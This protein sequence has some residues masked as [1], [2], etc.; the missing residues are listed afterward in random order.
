MFSEK[1]SQRGD[2]QENAEQ[3]ENKMKP[4]HQRDAAQDHDSAHDQR[5]EDSPH[6]R[7]MLSPRRH[8]EISK[9]Q[10]ENKDV[11]DAQRIF[12]EVSTKKIE[13]MLWSFE[14]P[15]QRV[16]AKRYQHPQNAPLSGSVHA[17]FVIAPFE[18]DQ[19]NGDRDKDADV[20]GD[21]K[22][23]AG[24]HGVLTFHGR[25]FTPIANTL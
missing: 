19:I 5:A 7:A 11:I 6:Q 21:P 15:H 16:E 12:D 25:R 17:Q 14:T 13:S 10:Y 22:P 9:N 2:Q 3:V 23:N 1:H 4:P 18:G 24:C 8:A 20:K